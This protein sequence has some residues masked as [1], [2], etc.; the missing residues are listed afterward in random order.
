MARVAEAI[1][2]AW[3]AK[4]TRV[5]AAQVLKGAMGVYSIEE[6]VKPCLCLVFITALNLC[7]IRW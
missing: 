1:R 6:R 3:A 4:S 2:V 7:K 5:R